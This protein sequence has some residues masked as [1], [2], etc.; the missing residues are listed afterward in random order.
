MPTTTYLVQPI[1]D[2]RNIV[3]GCRIIG[4]YENVVVVEVYALSYH[5]LDEV[6]PLDRFALEVHIRYPT[7]ENEAICLVWIIN[8]VFDI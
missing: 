6:I 1:K 8:Q 3:L 4:V 7:I 5:S 2:F